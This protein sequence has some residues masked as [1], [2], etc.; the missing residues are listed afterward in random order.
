MGTPVD[1]GT[2]LHLAIYWD[3]LDMATW[4]VDR[5]AD[6][7]ARAAIDADGFGGFT[8]LFNSVVSQAGF[9]INYPHGRE[10]R[11]GDRVHRAGCGRAAPIPEGARA[12]SPRL[13]EAQRH[14]PRE[15]P[16]PD[17]ANEMP[18]EQHPANIARSCS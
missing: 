5:G 16:R 15:F 12:D 2:L 14:P 6:P 11:P 18:R 10:F 3:E 17:A 1:G 8:P 9:W 7:N 13:G 4:L